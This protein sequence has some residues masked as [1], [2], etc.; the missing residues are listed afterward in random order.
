AAIVIVV[1]VAVFGYAAAGFA[2]ATSRLDGARNTY[3]AVVAHQNAITDTVNLFNTKFTATTAAATASDLKADRSLLDEVVSK[4]KAAETTS[5]ADDALLASAQASLTDSSWLTVFNRSNL[6]HYSSKIGHERKALGDSKTL[7]G[8][9]VLLATFYQSFFDALI[10]F[11]TVGNKIE[12]S[13]FQGALAGVS[14][15]QT[16]LGKALQASSAPG[17]PPQV[18]QFIVDFQTFATDEGKLLAAVNSSDVS[19]GQSLSPKVTADVTKLD[20]YDF[21]KI[22][23]DIA[24][25]YTPLIDDYNSEISKANSM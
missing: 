5:A 1:L 18:H 20:S 10:D 8:D 11:D 14:T 9:Y 16:D 17:L 19:A 3:N 23:T 13:D 22:G 7:T 6:D 2:F 21:T 15:L 25:Y 12:A 24:S 4:S